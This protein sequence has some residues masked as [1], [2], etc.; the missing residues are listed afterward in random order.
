MSHDTEIDKLEKE[1]P[2]LAKELC[3]KV[4]EPIRVK[5]RAG[6][7]QEGSGNPHYT[8]QKILSHV[9]TDVAFFDQ[10]MGD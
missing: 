1:A 7:P 2:A 10:F 5:G 3:M 4:S 8:V 9:S 6:R